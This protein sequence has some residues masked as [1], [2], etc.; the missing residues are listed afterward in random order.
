MDIEP[1]SSQLYSV[2]A[3][4]YDFGLWFFGYKL[5]VDYFIRL[6]PFKKTD[7]FKVIDVGCGTGLYTFALLKRFPHATVQAFD[8]NTDMIERMKITTRR[9][10]LDN[11]VVIF[12]ADVTK[13]LPIQPEQ[14]DLIITGGVLEYVNVGEAVKNL[15]PYLKPGGYFLNSPVKDNLLGRMVGKLYG[16]K[17]HSHA[18]NVNAFIGNGFA[19]NRT[20]SFP[21]IKEAHLFQ[22]TKSKDNQTR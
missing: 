15:A 12:N 21:I 19:L 9:K 3:R 13:P 2:I 17:P 8:I 5:A 22:I 7:S 14:F 1:N 4:F 20:R 10:N 6:L 18:V 16:F 11:Q